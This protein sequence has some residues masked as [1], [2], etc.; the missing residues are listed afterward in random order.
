MINHSVQHYSTGRKHRLVFTPDAVSPGSSDIY[1]R[2]YC[3]ESNCNPEILQLKPIDAV[4][5]CYYQFRYVGDY[6]LLLMVDGEL[7]FM[8]KAVVDR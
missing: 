8:L 3:P 4:Y 1:C 6:L 5:E 2:V 7:I